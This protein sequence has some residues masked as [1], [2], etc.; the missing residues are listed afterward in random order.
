M[1]SHM[2]TTRNA[3][4]GLIEILVGVASPTKVGMVRPVELSPSSDRAPVFPYS[5]TGTEVCGPP[6][7]A[8]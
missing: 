5:V 2:L 4:R 6:Q 1:D 7:P 3:R 8:K